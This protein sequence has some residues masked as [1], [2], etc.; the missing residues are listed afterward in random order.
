WLPAIHTVDPEGKFN[1]LVEP[2]AG[3]FVKEDGL[4]LEIATYLYER[5]RL[6][7]K[8]TYEH[9][10]PFC[11]RC[12]S[13]LLYYA[14]DTW[15]IRM[16]RI[17]D[18]MLSANENINWFPEHLKHGRFGN[19]LEDLK[20]WALSRNRFWGT[21]LPIWRCAEGHEICVGGF[22]ELASLT[23]GLPDGF[24][25]HRP[26]VDDLKVGCPQCGGEMAREPYVIDTW[27]DSGSAFFAQYHYPF[28]HCKEFESSYPVDFITE[29]LDQTRGWFYTLLAI[30]VSVFNKHTYRN[31]LTMGLILDDTGHKMSKSKG[32]VVLPEDVT[33]TFGA[34]AV[35]LNFYQTPVWNSYRFS[36][37]GVHETLSKDI[38][39]LWNVYAFFANNAM[40]DG[41]LPRPVEP[42][43]ELDRW[44]L[45]RLNSLCAQVREA[46][47][48]Y[49]LHVAAGAIS[50]FI[51]ELSNW[52]LRRSR[53][54][55]WLDSNPEDKAQAYSTLY[56]VLTELV[57]L[58]APFIPFLSEYLYQRL[59]VEIDPSAPEGVHLCPYPEVDEE[60]LSPILEKEMAMAIAA[61]RAGRNARQKVNIKLRQPL[62]RAV[63]IT[64]PDNAEGMR[65]FA[66]ILQ[67]ELNVK[68]IT[69][70]QDAKEY[71]ELSIKPNHA[72]IGPKFGA[73]AT[74]VS[75]ML[76]RTPPSEVIEALEREGMIKIGDRVIGREDVVV[77]YRERSGYSSSS[78]AGIMVVIHTTLSPELLSEGMARD[79]VRRIQ[80]MRSAL[81][82]S[83]DQ[84]I[85]VWLS[86]DKALLEAARAHSSYIEQETLANAIAWGEGRGRME[87]WKIDGRTLHVWVEPL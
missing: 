80:T 61:A 28:E 83:Y 11:W 69:I 7:S 82:L 63:V 72:S 68:E 31:V 52:Y 26:F 77:E 75:E 67:E 37:E 66:E 19:F 3:R 5:N 6:Y 15:F 86:G 10:Y 56:M 41:Y 13:P 81:S 36:K 55:F 20:D 34:D 49:E 2:W 30:G 38:N 59:V 76:A 79:I 85:N 42:K 27:Y 73:H 16:S 87:D 78:A 17:R 4:D 43:H 62:S 65:R 14:L 39:T 25:P 57:M 40:L 48:R 51:D 46:M 23:G 64:T 44:L 47:E 58:S 33:E 29:A 53:R 60:M 22:E 21:P 74:K 8:A 84:R 18:E 12:D 45:S 32:N 70:A 9:S 71:L 35:R 1:A 54:R 24:D 50:G